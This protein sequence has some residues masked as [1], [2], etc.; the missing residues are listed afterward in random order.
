[1]SPKHFPKADIQSCT[2]KEIKTTKNKITTPEANMDDQR[3]KTKHTNLNKLNLEKK[4]NKVLL[5]IR[6]RFPFC[7]ID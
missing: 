6:L 1:M 4:Y 7:G 3:I 2:R 5:F